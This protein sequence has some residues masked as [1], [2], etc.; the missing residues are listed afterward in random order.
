M[1][2]QPPTALRVCCKYV[3]DAGALYGAVMLTAS[4]VIK[5]PAPGYKVPGLDAAPS[6]ETAIKA[7][8]VQVRYHPR[9]LRVRTQGN[10]PGFGVD[11]LRSAAA[12]ALLQVNQRPR[13]WTEN[14]VS[15]GCSRLDRHPTLQAA[16]YIGRAFFAF[17]ARKND[18]I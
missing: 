12:V 14:Y 13:M 3:V 6:T 5:S 17:L 8:V 18:A 11:D 4:M 10:S 15:C 1:R 9:M 16:G 7:P 2:P